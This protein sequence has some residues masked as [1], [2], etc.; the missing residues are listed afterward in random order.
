MASH[1]K[2]N[3]EFIM[4]TCL[5]ARF[6]KFL[7]ASFCFLFVLGGMTFFHIPLAVAGGSE[8]IANT[9]KARGDQKQGAMDLYAGHSDASLG[10]SSG[11][12][13]ANQAAAHNHDE[14]ALI[15]EACELAGTDSYVPGCK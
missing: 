11:A 14:S 2:I 3:G 15:N 5:P 10:V 6:R 13:A 12:G 1:L 7:A 8:T 4:N 9:A